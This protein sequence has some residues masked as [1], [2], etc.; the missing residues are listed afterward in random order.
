MIYSHPFSK[1]LCR[2]VSEVMERALILLFAL[3]L[4][5]GGIPPPAAQ[6]HAF[7]ERAEPKVGSAVQSSPARVRIWFDGG[8][9]PAFSSIRVMDANHQAVDKG[10]GHVNE[11]ESTLLEVILPALPPGPYHVFWVAISLDGHRTEGDFSF[12]VETPP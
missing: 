11:H 3:G 1:S 8:L 12:T 5:A 2:G 6:A 9:E 10:D 4:A 7:P